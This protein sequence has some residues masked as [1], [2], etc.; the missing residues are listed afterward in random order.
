LE[1]DDLLRAEEELEF[2]LFLFLFF[3]VAEMGLRSWS[4]GE[5][6]AVICFATRVS[7]T[8]FRRRVLPVLLRVADDTEDFRANWCCGVSPS[9]S[10]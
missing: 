1:A 5:E 6:V 10:P 9:S 8:L 2:N 4:N 3:A 7:P